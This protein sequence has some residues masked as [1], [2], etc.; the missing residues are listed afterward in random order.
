MNSV[1]LSAHSEMPI[2]TTL[3]TNDHRKVANNNKNTKYKLVSN[4]V[5]IYRS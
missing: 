1:A 4:Y 2:Y 5:Y 3:F